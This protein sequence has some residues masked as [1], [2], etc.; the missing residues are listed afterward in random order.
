MSAEDPQEDPQA[1]PKADPKPDPKPDPNP[2]DQTEEAAAGA[3]GD[4]PAAKKAK[5]EDGDP[6]EA[7]EEEDKGAAAAEGKKEAETG[8]DEAG[9]K[10][11]AFKCGKYDEKTNTATD[12]QPISNVPIRYCKD[13]DEGASTQKADAGT[14]PL[15]AEAETQTDGKMLEKTLKEKNISPKQQKLIMDDSKTSEAIVNYARGK[16]KIDKTN[17]EKFLEDIDGLDPDGMV[18]VFQE[19]RAKIKKNSEE[20]RD[21][22]AATATVGGSR[23]GGKRTRRKKKKRRKSR[24]K[25]SRRKKR[26]KSRRK[27]SPKRRKSRRKKS[28][29]RRKSRKR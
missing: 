8:A 12:C 5:E 15:T 13:D 1:D 14:G 4:P 23:R 19:L 29:K 18:E 21:R 25:K 7:G 9:Q 3:D 16:E 20:V 27:K 28:P 11:G 24:R 2:E 26:G 17:V 22:D 6:V 10:S